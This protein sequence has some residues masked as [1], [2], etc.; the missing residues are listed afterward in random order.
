VRGR[1][2][3]LIG[4]AEA[5]IT[6]A[7]PDGW[8]AAFAA[9]LKACE[10][11]D[12][13][14]VPRGKVKAEEKT[15]VSREH[16]LMVFVDWAEAR[17]I[18]FMARPFT[19]TIRD[20]LRERI[21]ASIQPTTLW[22]GDD[23][24]LCGWGE[25]MAAKRLCEPLNR[26]RIQ[27][28]LP[29]RPP[30]VIELPGFQ[31]D[32]DSLRFFR[33]LGGRPDRR[34]LRRLTVRLQLAGEATAVATLRLAAYLHYAETMQH[35]AMQL[36]ARKMAAAMAVDGE[37]S[38]EG[39]T[40]MAD[41]ESAA[42]ALARSISNATDTADIQRNWAK[43]GST[44]RAAAGPLLPLGL[45]DIEDEPID[46]LDILAIEPHLIARAILDCQEEVGDIALSRDV[47]AWMFEDCA[48]I[49]DEELDALCSA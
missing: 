12:N 33:D 14:P 5:A 39:L 27:E 17:G 29:H 8:R 13:R 37:L 40:A 20:F 18:A 35:R 43:V 26:R 28:V 3:L 6:E 22:S 10:P 11:K 34:G 49:S 21:A 9:D 1:L 24:K 16:K 41:D 15:N 38:A 4:R 19:E 45:A 48:S 32:L 36:M 31:A 46:G 7:G 42:M 23:Q 47:L 25:W 2:S 44:R 30:P